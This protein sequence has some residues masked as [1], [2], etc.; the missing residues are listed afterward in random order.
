MGLLKNSVLYVTNE[1]I[2]EDR[3]PTKYSL[4]WKLSKSPFQEYINDDYNGLLLKKALEQV[5]P[6]RRLHGGCHSMSAPLE[7]YGDTYRVSLIKIG[8]FLRA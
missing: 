5:C 8:L 4:R 7:V 3:E 2:V 1:D 6:N